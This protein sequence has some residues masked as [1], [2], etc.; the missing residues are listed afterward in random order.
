MDGD[1]DQCQQYVKQLKEALRDIKNQ[2]K[3]LAEESAQYKVTDKYASIIGQAGAVTNRLDTLMTDVR[4]LLHWIRLV[5][6][7]IAPHTDPRNDSKIVHEYIKQIRADPT[8]SLATALSKA[9]ATQDADPFAMHSDEDED[10]VAD[11]DGFMYQ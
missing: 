4:E 5:V 10:D 2:Q 7:V 11:M 6:P 8:K 3:E 9:N 1:K